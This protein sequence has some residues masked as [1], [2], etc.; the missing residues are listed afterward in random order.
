MVAACRSFNKA[1]P[2]VEGELKLHLEV[3][4][5]SVF[6]G[7]FARTFLTKLCNKMVTPRSTISR[8]ISSRSVGIFV[9]TKT[10]GKEIIINR[11]YLCISLTAMNPPVEFQFIF[12]IWMRFVETPV[13]GHHHS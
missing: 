12:C 5:G 11:I 3:R 4:S 9:S 6:G 7:L 8:H 1:H 2:N 10:E 13:G